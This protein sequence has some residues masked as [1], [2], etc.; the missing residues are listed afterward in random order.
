MSATNFSRSCRIKK[1]ARQQARAIVDTRGE[2]LNYA[3]AQHP[4]LMAGLVAAFARAQTPA[5]ALRLGVCCGSGTAA[6]PGTELF[7]PQ[8][9]DGLMAQ[10]NVES[11]DI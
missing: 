1:Y 5:E 10:V 11:L 4:F 7:D 3:L 9:L 6:Q 8:A 2:A